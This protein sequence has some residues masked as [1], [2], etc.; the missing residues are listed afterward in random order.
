MW[1]ELALCT[2]TIAE[3]YCTVRSV[4]QY[5][6]I[7]SHFLSCNLTYAHGVHTDPDWA[8]TRAPATVGYCSAPQW[9]HCG[10]HE[11]EEE[12]FY[13]QRTRVRSSENQKALVM[14]EEC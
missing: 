14:S 2:E 7:R 3:R 12:N 10:I 6:C 4:M 11:S 8:L 5:P 9:A 13:S 1:L